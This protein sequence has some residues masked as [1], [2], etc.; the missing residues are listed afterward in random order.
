MTSRD[1]R[2]PVRCFLVA[3]A[4]ACSVLLAG[5]E[6]KPPQQEFLSRHTL[7][8]DYNARAEAI[9]RLWSRCHIDVDMPKSSGDPAATKAAGRET[10]SADGHF[11]F[12]KPR[13]L[14][15]QGKVP[16]VGAVFGLHS[17]QDEYWFW[18]KPGQSCEWK[19]HHGGAGQDR[20][21]LRPDRLLETLG[22]F[23]VPADGRAVFRRDAETDVIQVLAESPLPPE[24]NSGFSSLYVV[25]EIH[26][27]RLKHDPVSVRL[28]SPS[29]EPLVVSQLSGYR[30]V[31]GQR[32]PGTMIF[33]FLHLGQVRNET[34]VTLKFKDIT[35]TKDLSEAAFA[36][37]TPPVDRH[38]DVD[39][40]EP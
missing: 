27:D 32:I 1:R 19:G 15:L 31:D 38:V 14:I 26:L 12:A 4:T 24:A 35:L 5:C 18:V 6:P 30:E 7:L 13:N 9:T 36:Y 40:D 21:F 3:F 37:R 2:S 11:I 29:G 8:A 25:Q 16:F 10:Y 23:A 28:L 34:V 33:R 39:S 22:M 17:N 20:L